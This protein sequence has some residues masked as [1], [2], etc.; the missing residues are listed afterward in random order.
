MKVELILLPIA[1]LNGQLRFYVVNHSNLSITFPMAELLED[2]LIFEATNA[3]LNQ[4]FAKQN[5]N[6][7]DFETWL[8]SA[9]CKG[10]MVDVY[11][12]NR[13][14]EKNNCLVLVQAIS[15][16]ES[17]AKATEDHWLGAPELLESHSKLTADNKLFLSACLNLIPFW[18]KNSSFAF[19]LM[20]SIF[21]I[22]ELR[23]LVATLA[24]QEVDPGNFHRRL[25]KL[26]ILKPL[27]TGFQRV[28]RWEFAWE[29]SNAL[30][31]DG[32]IP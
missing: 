3:I 22:Q 27:G 12:K 11:D 24:N 2:P 4:Y 7:P 16:P 19:E 21:S 10:R 15:I 31:S 17:I 8:Y 23:L 26:D 5:S 6:N 30:S 1:V 14:V 29:R 28:H 25:K 32:L 13:L 18:V 20:N 9:Q